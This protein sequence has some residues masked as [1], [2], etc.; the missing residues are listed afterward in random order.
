MRDANSKVRLSLTHYSNVELSHLEIYD[1][2]SGY[3]IV[4]MELTP[5]KLRHLLSSRV[6]TEDAWTIQRPERDRL[7]MRLE[8]ATVYPPQ[9][10]FGNE[11]TPELEEWAES[12]RDD[13]DWDEVQLR[14]HNDG[15]AAHLS[16]YHATEGLHA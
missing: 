2:A 15:W 4:D 11:P 6:I 9:R 7:G 10:Y 14:H 8:V 3:C 16:R 1:E 13:D 5:G 12:L